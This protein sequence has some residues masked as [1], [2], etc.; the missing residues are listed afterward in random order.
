VHRLGTNALGQDLL[1]QWLSGARTSLSIGVG[2]AAVS[3]AL[4]GAGGILAEVGGLSRGPVLVLTDGLLAIPHLPLIILIVS[5][6]GPGWPT[7]VAVLA[8]VGWPAYARVVRAQV[9]SLLR[10]EFVEAARA[11]GATTARIVRT[12]VLPEIAPLLWTKFLLTMRWAILMEATL[13]LLGLSD[14]ARVSWGTVLSDAFAYPLLFV[15]N[16][17]LWWALPPALSIAALTLALAMLGH[18]FETWLN[19]GRPPGAGPVQAGGPAI[20]AERAMSS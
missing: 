4:S 16:A 19:P 12:C 17:W 1:S 5:L 14:P 3:T 8:L 13:A 6:V 7:L 15:G 10:R 2:V 18:D 11:A 20:R 9:Q